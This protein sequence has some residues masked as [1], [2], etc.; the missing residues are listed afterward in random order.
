MKISTSVDTRQGPVDAATAKVG[1]A[2]PGSQGRGDWIGLAGRT[3]SQLWSGCCSA[4]EGRHGVGE[5]RLVGR[6]GVGRCRNVVEHGR[7][8]VKHGRNVVEHGF[9]VVGLWH[10][11]ADRH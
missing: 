6:D 2:R 3:R 9:A 5:V 10:G 8:V 1:S 4:M 11:I 7:N